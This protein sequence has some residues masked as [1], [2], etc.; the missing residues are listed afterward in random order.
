[1]ALGF[2]VPVCLGMLQLGVPALLYSYAIKRVTALE[3]MLIPALEPILNPIWVA[4][5]LPEQP[6]RWAVAGG[7]VV[8][9]T[10]IVRGILTARGAPRLA[11]RRPP[12]TMA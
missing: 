7:I 11:S 2:I 9:G 4:M 6:G 3:S 1:V 12:G 5:F 10:V 8:L